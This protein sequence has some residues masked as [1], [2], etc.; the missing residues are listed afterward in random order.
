MKHFLE[1]LL[2]CLL[3]AVAVSQEKPIRSITSSTMIG[4]GVS[5][6]LDTYLTPLDYMGAQIQLINERLQ[7]ASYGKG[8]WVNQQLV[9]ADFSANDNEA[10]NGLL[11]SGFLNYSWTTMRR[12]QVMPGL[13]LMAGPM[14]M[15]ETGFI[16]NVRNTN[17]PVSAKLAL[18]VGGSAMAI[19]QIN[20]W[21]RFP[22]T[23]RYQMSMPMMR[24]FFSPHY[25]QSYYEIFSLG[26]KKGIFRFGSFNNTFDMN[27]LLTLDM[28]L[29]A[30][31][32]RIGFYT[33]IQNTHVYQ[34][35]NRRISN[36]F[37][38]GI[39]KEFLPFRKKTNNHQCQPY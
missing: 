33:K 18:A 19:Y 25:E 12:A 21:P 6:I 20:I 2:M 15:G 24:V 22:I 30:L 31:N 7:V 10:Q 28:P 38:V 36:T 27:S 8:K 11:M 37:L 17:N 3:P 32:L 29:G 34:I 5:E 14:A 35:K 13:T 16:Y 23:A 1:L 26:N 9:G 39:S 4:L